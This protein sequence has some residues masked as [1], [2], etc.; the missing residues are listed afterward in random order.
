[1]ASASGTPTLDVAAMQKRKA[2]IVKG[3]TGGIA[4]LFKS[5]GVTALPG[6]GRLLAGKARWSTP[7]PMAQSSTLQATHVIL[8]SGSDADGAASTVAQ[9]GK[10]IVDSWG[11]LEFDAVPGATRRHRRRSH[12]PGTGQRLAAPGRQGHVLEAMPR[13]PGRGRSAARRRGPEAAAQA[14][15][16]HPL[17]A[18]VSAA[19]VQGEEVAVQ[20]RRMRRA[21]SSSI[22]RP[23][24]RGG[25]SS[26]LSRR[27]CWAKAPGVELDAARLH[28]GR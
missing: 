14:G 17:G 1:M 19:A 23:P 6:H 16:G 3:M 27:I 7:L 20:L 11:A 24:G 13:F 28:R 8:A 22:V 26:T 10:L 18:K 5:G 12:R 25:R 21:S 2:G 9:D 15:A 4:A